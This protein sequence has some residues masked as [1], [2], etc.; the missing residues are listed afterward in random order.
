MGVYIYSIR[1]KPKKILFC[2]EWVEAYPYEFAYK[3]YFGDDGL[4]N[5]YYGKTFQGIPDHKL[6]GI[7]F[8]FG[9]FE[10]RYAVYK[11]D[12]GFDAPR[13]IEEEVYDKD[14]NFLSPIT[15]LGELTPIGKRGRG[16]LWGVDRNPAM[17]RKL[18]KEM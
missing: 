1:N 9:G 17:I 14:N 6:L 8:V 11:M 7:Y 2:D 4:R 15:Y 5:R 18:S 12:D 10:D 3:K 13:L 16:I